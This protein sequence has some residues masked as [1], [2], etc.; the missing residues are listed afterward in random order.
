MQLLF[1]R[2][3]PSLGYVSLK[4]GCTNYVARS[5]QRTN[6]QR[7]TKSGG[8]R[9]RTD[10]LEV[11]SLASYL[12]APPRDVEFIIVTSTVR[13]GKCQLLAG[14][15]AAMSSLLTIGIPG[16]TPRPAFNRA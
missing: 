1:H 4:Q 10:D 12:A 13:M 14:F 6:Q 9:I 7:L 2:N 8:G 5:S 3:I 16:Q 11:M 15:P